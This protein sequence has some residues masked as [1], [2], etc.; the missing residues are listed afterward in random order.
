[1]N[2]RLGFVSNSSSSNFIVSTSGDEAWVEVRIN[3]AAYAEGVV[4]TKAE[5]D[6]YFIERFGWND[7]TDLDAIFE[8]SPIYAKMY[9]EA[10][11]ALDR[12]ETVLLG[13]FSSDS[14]DSA[15]LFLYDNGIPKTPGVKIIYDG[16]Y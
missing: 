4:K 2:I 5:L 6:E 1:M 16:G 11:A 10:S 3:I 8:E 15:E 13:S 14:D 12:G 9:E 7:D